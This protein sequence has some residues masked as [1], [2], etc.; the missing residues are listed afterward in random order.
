MENNNNEL[1]NKEENNKN[2][3]GGSMSGPAFSIIFMII[4]LIG[5]WLLSKYLG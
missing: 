4:T 2:Y 1:N 5:M 3:S